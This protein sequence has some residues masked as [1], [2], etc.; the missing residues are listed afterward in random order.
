M[1]A[2]YTTKKK[3]KVIRENIADVTFSLQHF[4]ILILHFATYLHWGKMDPF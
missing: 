2:V 3:P 1:V 4:N